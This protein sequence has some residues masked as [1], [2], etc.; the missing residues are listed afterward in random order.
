MRKVDPGSKFAVAVRRNAL[1]LE[2]DGLL[3]IER[4]SKNRHV[5]YKLTEKGRKWAE[6]NRRQG[7]DKITSLQ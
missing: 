7:L 4:D 5:R 1:S 3:I 6:E 2:A